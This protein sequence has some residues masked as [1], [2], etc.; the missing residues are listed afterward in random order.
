ML[1]LSICVTVGMSC[2]RRFLII[3]GFVIVALM[4]ITHFRNRL[5][6]V[7]MSSGNM[8]R[9]KPCGAKHEGQNHSDSDKNRFT[10]R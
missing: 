4:V 7:A 10:H 2:V 6:F 3:T 5:I 9:S 1:V 8:N